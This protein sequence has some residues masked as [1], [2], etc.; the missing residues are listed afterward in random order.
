[1]KNPL[2]IV[3]LLFSCL[4]LVAE[5]EQLEEE[6]YL[7]KAKKA[8][9]TLSSNGKDLTEE[10]KEWIRQDVGNIGDWEYKI[11]EINYSDI[12]QFESKLNSL[13]KERWECF[14]I[15]EQGDEILCFFKRPKISYLQKISQA[16]FSK[17]LP[18]SE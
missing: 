17:L 16:N 8:Y 1:M 2:L 12:E 3:I 6:T 7:E 14:W 15:T 18:D 4:G 9:E 13:G 10:T 5:E 11:V